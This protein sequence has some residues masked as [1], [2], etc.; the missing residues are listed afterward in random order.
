MIQHSFYDV[1][2][3]YYL[4]L[5]IKKFFTEVWQTLN[6]LLKAVLTDVQVLE[7]IAGCKALG[8]VNKIIPGPLWLVLESQE[9]SILSMNEKFCHL[10]SC[11]EQ[12][13]HDATPVL[14]GEV[15]LYADYLP[16]KTTFLTH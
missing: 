14:S 10:K 5:L 6:Q 13:S 16:P 9:I 3:V 12:W 1:G 8:L 2:A 11:L 7:Y 15:V 4:S